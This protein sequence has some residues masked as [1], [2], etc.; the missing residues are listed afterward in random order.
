MFLDPP[1]NMKAK[2]GVAQ[3]IYADEDY[4]DEPRYGVVQKK[5]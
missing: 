1:L 2:Y 4:E 3:K 5:Y